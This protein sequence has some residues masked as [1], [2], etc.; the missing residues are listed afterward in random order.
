[1]SEALDLYD[2]LL[3]CALLA[4]VADFYARRAARSLREGASR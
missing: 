3:R 2:D 4:A 1:M